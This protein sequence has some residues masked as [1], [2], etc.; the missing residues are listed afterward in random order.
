M[1]ALEWSGVVWAGVGIHAV[2]SLHTQGCGRC[3][4]CNRNMF[5][6]ESVI[7]MLGVL[8][9]AWGLERPHGSLSY[10]NVLLG[11]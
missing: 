11:R 10:N 8:V 5:H 9:M 3:R 1:S 7:W 4:A 2:C 6:G